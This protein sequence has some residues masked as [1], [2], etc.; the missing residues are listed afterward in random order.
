MKVWHSCVG[1]K[2]TSVLGSRLQ[3]LGG[4]VFLPSQAQGHP[5]KQQGLRELVNS[6]HLLG[7]HPG[8]TFQNESS[9]SRPLSLKAHMLSP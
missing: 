6:F 9:T 3:T 5:G 2:A 4:D 1:L 7:T 8:V